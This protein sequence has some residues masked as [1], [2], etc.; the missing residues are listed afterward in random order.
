[1]TRSNPIHKVR[2]FGIIAHIDAGKTTTSERILLY[3]GVNHKIGEVHDGGATMDWM[4]QEK[5]RGITITSAATVCYWDAPKGT[6]GDDTDLQTR[7]NIIDTPGHVDFTIEVE[8]SLRVLDG[9]ITVFDAV[10][11]VEAQSETVWRQAEKYNV[12]RICFINKLDRTGANFFYDIDSIKDRLT[13]HGVVMQLPIG[14]EDQFKG[15]VDL[16]T[17]RAI[18]YYDDLGKDI[19]DEEIPADMVEIANKYRA[20]MIEKVAETDDILMEKFL[21]EKEITNIELKAAIRAA[22]IACK[23]HPIFT[24]T[25]LKNKGVQPLLDAVCEYLPSP[26]DIAPA[27][28]HKVEEP[29]VEFNV[30][31]SDD[32]PMRALAFKIATDSFGSL[33]FFRVY[34]GIVKK[35]DELFNPRTGKTER[36]GRIVLL[37]SN[38]R[39]DVD[40]V[41]AGEIGAFIGLKDVRTGD[42]LCLKSDRTILESINI[43]ESVISIAVEPK[44]KNDQDKMGI[45]LGKLVQEDPSLK[46][47]TNEETGQVIMSGMGELHLEIIVDRMKRE[48]G[49]ETNVGAP[50]VAYKEAITTNIEIQGKHVR[51]SGGRGQFGDCWLR[52]KPLERGEGFKFVNKIVG[53]S[54]PKEFIPAIQKGCEEIMQSGALAGYP[55]IDVAVELFDGSYHDVDSSEMAFQI[56]GRNGMKEGILKASPV[57]LEPIMKLEVSAPKEYMGDVIGSINSRRGQVIGQE[58]RGKSVIIKA[59]VPLEKLFGY[60]SDLRGSTKGQGAPSMEFSHYAPVPRNVQETIVAARGK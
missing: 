8:R 33:T 40:E 15:L 13:D 28:G 46:V 32:E 23:L 29:D 10:A 16:M 19:R 4:E 54:I 11:G 52:I 9:A 38:N 37:H 50:Q 41:Y 22:T 21:E 45:A 2:N 6:Y 35:G 58:E 43:P 17:M 30:I 44:T 7:F 51:Q 59:E 39:K 36:A 60:V 34:S 42:T 47:A 24:G 57:L 55:I 26:I 18:V 49:V 25:A 56:A 1:M 31:A 5:E 48:Y 20:M 12:P 53:G 27:K 3:T 14:V